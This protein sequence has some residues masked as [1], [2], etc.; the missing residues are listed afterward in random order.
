MAQRPGPLV[1]F[2]IDAIGDAHVADVPVRGSKAAFDSLG[3]MRCQRFKE[4]RPM[5][6]RMSIAAHR[7]SSATPGKRQVAVQ[8]QSRR[9]RLC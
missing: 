2:T 4:A 7:S 1:L 5:R 9:N 6:M 8:C 3:A